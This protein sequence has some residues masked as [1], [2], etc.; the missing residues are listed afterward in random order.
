MSKLQAYQVVNKEGKLNIGPAKTRKQPAKAL[1]HI[2]KEIETGIEQFEVLQVW[3]TRVQMHVFQI[4]QA[5]P[6]YFGSKKVWGDDTT[7]SYRPI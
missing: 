4:S 6:H 2:R 7:I 1:E 5:R 3:F